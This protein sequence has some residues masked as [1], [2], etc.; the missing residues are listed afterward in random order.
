MVRLAM[1][2][3]AFVARDAEGVEDVLKVLAGSVTVRGVHG[4]KPVQVD[5]AWDAT[6][7]SGP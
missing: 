6:G 5:G 3:H 4:G 2:N 1:G 7:P